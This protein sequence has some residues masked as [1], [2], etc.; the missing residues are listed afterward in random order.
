MITVY[1]LHCNVIIIVYILPCKVIIIFS[2][3]LCKVIINMYIPLCKV[4][5]YHH[6]VAYN[7]NPHLQSYLHSLH[8]TLQSQFYHKST[9]PSTKLPYSIVIFYMFLYNVSNNVTSLH[10][11]NAL[12]RSA[13]WLYSSGL[14]QVMPLQGVSHDYIHL[15]YSRWCP[16][17]YI[18][19]VMWLYSSGF[20]R[21]CPCKECSVTIFIWYWSGDALMGSVAW[22]YHKLDNT[23]D[24]I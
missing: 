2:I 1:L 16:Y 12:I 11:G 13:T 14:F 9:C 21:W 10:P 6:T 18:R 22:G 19:S 23:W 5:S 4:L 3:F 24:T 7:L 8:P 17:I 15:V 20:S